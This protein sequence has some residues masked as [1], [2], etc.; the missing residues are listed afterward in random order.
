MNADAYAK[1]EY[2]IMPNIENLRYEVINMKDTVIEK[3]V[4]MQFTGSSINQLKQYGR[5]TIFHISDTP[6]YVSIT[7]EAVIK[8]LADVD[9]NVEAKL[10]EVCNRF[11]KSDRESHKK[12]TLFQIEKL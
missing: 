2:N 10:I 3:R 8:I 4:K 11:G 7:D 1:L 12:I 9:V 5:C 6:D